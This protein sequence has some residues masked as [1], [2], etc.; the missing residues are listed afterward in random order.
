MS[1]ATAAGRDPLNS[2]SAP[3]ARP[4]LLDR[5]LLRASSQQVI[6]VR[7]TPLRVLLRSVTF[8]VLYWWFATGAIFAL[9]GSKSTSGAFKKNLNAK[10]GRR[11]PRVL[12]DA[13]YAK[14]PDARKKIEQAIDKAARAVAN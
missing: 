12:S 6:A 11:W 5:L 3:T 4:S 14:G 13:L 9:A 10:H 1:D 7:E 8:V 2:A